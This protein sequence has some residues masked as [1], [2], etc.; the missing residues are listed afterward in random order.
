[1]DGIKQFL[2]THNKKIMVTVL[3]ISVLSFIVYN[4]FHF[5]DTDIHYVIPTGRYILE[6]GIPRENPFTIVS[7]LN[8][9]I[10][11][12]LYSVVLAFFYNNLHTF[13][14]WILQFCT[15]ILFFLCVF[16][17]FNFK[18]SNYKLLIAFFTVILLYMFGY[19]NLRAELLTFILLVVEIHSIERFRDTGKTRYLWL[20]PL[21]VLLEINCHASYWIMHY[22][23]LLPYVVPLPH[24]IGLKDVHISGKYF[25][26]MLPY[27]FFSIL[28]LFL[29]PYGVGNIMYVFYALS[30]G[31]LSFSGILEQNPFSIGS[32][33]SIC[34]IAFLMVFL[35]MFYKKKLLSTEFY[36]YIGFSLLFFFAAK[37]LP[38]YT[39]SLMYLFRCLYRQVVLKK[40]L[41][42]EDFVLPLYF[43]LIVAI[44]NVFLMGLAI[45]SKQI[46]IVNVFNTTSDYYMDTYGNDKTS[47]FYSLDSLA[48]Y[49]D[50]N[51]PDATVYARFE[52]SNYFEFRGYKIFTDSR[53]EL[54]V[55][56]IC[57][58][59]D[60]SILY[61][62]IKNGYDT[63]SLH[64]NKSK[65]IVNYALTYGLGKEDYVLSYEE[66]GRAVDSVNADYYVVDVTSELALYHYLDNS[67]DKYECVAI[68]G[69]YYMFKR[70]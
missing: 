61:F 47:I 4:S 49:L 36:M 3:W 30:S 54:Y 44:S 39:I 57:G 41:R 35:V 12:W 18:E 42:I 14:L 56:E 1:M 26:K 67:V 52:T 33:Y 15:I 32:Q 16:K 11:N 51:A 55:K 60:L 66:Y 34:F 8:I 64:R 38:F 6:N 2:I 48:D 43:S 65:N 62:N 9:I 29:N 7:G 10:Q 24:F 69:E 37:W 50:D 19:V 40:L 20:L 5:I 68:S 63:I 45:Y 46:D 58:T 59:D 22:I 21:T 27:L 25:I 23:V 17:F 70:L 13:G 53:P 28:M 31:V